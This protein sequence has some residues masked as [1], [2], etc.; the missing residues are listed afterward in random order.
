MVAGSM[1]N[2]TAPGTDPARTHMKAWI[3]QRNDPDPRKA[4]ILKD[5]PDLRPGP[6]Q[7]LL[8]NEG[9][10]LNYA[11]VMA[12]KG[13]YRDAPPP[14]CIIGYEVVGRVQACGTGVPP[15][16]V[17]QRVV[18]M[19]RFGGYAEQA[20]TDFRAIAP[21]PEGMGVGEA[22]ALA[23]Q[24]CTAWYMANYACVLRKGQRVVIHSAAGGVG[25]LLVQIAVRRGC[26]VFAVASSE[27]K[28][29]W[30]RDLGAHHVIDRSV[31]D[32]AGQ[33]KVLLKEARVDVSFNAVGGSTFRKDM[34][35][36]N[37]GGALVLYGGAERGKGNGPFATLGFVWR[38]GLTVPILLM[39]KSQS[40]IGVNM[41]RISEHHPALLAQCAHEVVAAAGNGWLKPHVEKVFAA[42]QL[43]EA[44]A[45]L[46]SGQSMGKVAVKW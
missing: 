45:L 10:G 9:F 1:A 11:D 23:T 2:F 19:T 8:R 32:H 38:M 37:A 39:M 17:N 25:N 7:V 42:E 43:P 3:L 12:R 28:M 29:E 46:E 44:Q 35:L 6:G 21:V 14:P 5:V 30:L 4:F 16:L 31:S 13:L 22:S 34:A 41:L 24:G 18:A 20:V 27:R 26:E 33:L 15:E 40:L 36:L